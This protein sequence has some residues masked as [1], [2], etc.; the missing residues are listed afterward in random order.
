MNK[1]YFRKLWYSLS[2]K[3]R[4]WV[5]YLYYLPADLKDKI[6]GNRNKY[7]PPRGAIYTGSASGADK[8]LASS[9]HQL[10]LLK[11]E[12]NLQPADRVLD[13]GS[14][15]GR[16]AISLVEYLTPEARYEGFDVVK[17]GVDWCNKKIGRDFPN[18]NFT[19]VPLFNDLYNN[20][21]GK[22][23][24]FKFPYGDS[25]FDKVYSFSVFT[26]MM[27]DEIQHYLTEINRVL[28][29][30]G[31]AMSTFFLYDEANEEQIASDEGFGFPVAGDG[32]RLMNSKVT[33]GN[34]A[35]HKDHLEQMMSKAGLEI[36][37]I[38]DGFWKG[39]PEAKEYQDI[40]VFKKK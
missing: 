38:A 27:V 7:I 1:K 11:S 22:A 31:Q 4:F 20:S 33:S 12:V 23:T 24:E 19:Y 2:A 13:I 10:A 16:T 35:I 29:P 17:S 21:K 32:F 34:I 3:Q 18:F 30:D 14:G 37:R 39:T 36:T 26:H 25:E 9:K 40:V 8:F 15:I 6:K 5:R 28:A